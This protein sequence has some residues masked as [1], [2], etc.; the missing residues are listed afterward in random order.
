LDY[1]DA[2]HSFDVAVVVGVEGL[3]DQFGGGSARSPCRQ[4][5]LPVFAWELKGSDLTAREL[6]DR[7]GDV[8]CGVAAWPLDIDD[9]RRR[10]VCGEIK[11]KFGRDSSYIVGVDCR[12]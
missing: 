10:T 1:L 9:S 12:K 3:C 11:K 8:E 4:D 7:V 5:G 6:S 2:C